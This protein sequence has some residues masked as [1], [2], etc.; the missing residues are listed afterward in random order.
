MDQQQ[1]KAFI[2]AMAASDL[3]EAEFS[4]DGWTLRLV[5]SGAA[6]QA[7]RGAEVPAPS[8]RDAPPAAAPAKELTAPLFGV[9]HLQQTP[10]DP[11]F[12]SVGQ[13]V[14]AGQTLCVI[15]AMKVF[16]EVVAEHDG[17]VAAV[18]VTSGQEVEAGQPLLRY[19]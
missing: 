2:D 16:N 11:P 18:L 6:V 5:R 19:A 13:A 3:T 14:Q 1:I 9:V 17:T 10:G 12:V 8:R 4:Q 7:V 15:E